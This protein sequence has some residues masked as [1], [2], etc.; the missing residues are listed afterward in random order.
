MGR[1]AT[2][3]SHGGGQLGADGWCADAVI[4]PERNA[5][6]LEDVPDAVR[7]EMTFHPVADVRDVLRIAL[8]P[9]SSGSPAALAA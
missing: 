1:I 6:D 9:E 5:P 4:L 3:F 7:D 8:E 2:A